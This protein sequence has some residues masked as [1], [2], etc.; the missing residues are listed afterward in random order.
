[1]LQILGPKAGPEHWAVLAGFA[2][3]TA[4]CYICKILKFFSGLPNSRS[5]SG[6]IIQNS[7]NYVIVKE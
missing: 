6:E 4:L 5:V 3:A 1:M 7:L 2:H